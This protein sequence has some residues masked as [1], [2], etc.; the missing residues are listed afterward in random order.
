MEFSGQEYWSG[1]PF[2]SPG[3]LPNPGII[4]RSPTLQAD[5]L[6]LGHLGSWS[7]K[8]GTK[9]EESPWCNLR[10]DHSLQAQGSLGTIDDEALV[11]PRKDELSLTGQSDHKVQILL[12]GEGIVCRFILRGSA[13]VVWRAELMTKVG[14]KKSANYHGA[15]SAEGRQMVKS[16]ATLE[17]H[18]TNWAVEL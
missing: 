3:D 18:G 14:K 2:P 13:K 12:A 5:S 10:E 15:L 8:Y 16:T 11:S 4:S 6:P 9:T 17:L 1:L 7:K